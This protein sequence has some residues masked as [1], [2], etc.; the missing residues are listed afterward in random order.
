MCAFT[1]D[2]KILAK[3]KQRQERGVGLA[4]IWLGVVELW[5]KESRTITTERRCLRPSIYIVSPVFRSSRVN[6]LPLGDIM[7]GC[8]VGLYISDPL[9]DR[10]VLSIHDV[11]ITD[12][13]PKRKVEQL[14]VSSRS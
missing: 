4:E 10:L 7:A 14:I 13:V 6:V 12:L 3:S 11:Q 9:S 5:C 1:R 8:R 2:K